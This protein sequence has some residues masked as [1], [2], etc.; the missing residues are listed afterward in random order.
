MTELRR[1]AHE[2][3]RDERRS[4]A[5]A[6]GN[7]F[8]T[9]E[10][11]ETWWRHY[12]G[13]RELLLHALLDEDG[14]AGLLPLYAWR[15]GVVRTLGHGAGDELGP[16]ARPGAEACVVEAA[17]GLARPLLIADHV[18][19]NWIGGRQLRVERS[20]VIDATVFEGWDA[21]LRS[22]SS[23]LRRQVRSRTRKLA[24]A[25]FREADSATLEADLDTLFRLHRL[26][27]PA[28]S[29]FSDREAF[30][31]DFAR[32]G[33]ERGW[34]S[35][36]VLEVGGVAAAAWYGFRFADV[37]AY[38]QSGRD[39]AFDD[40][41]VGLVLL[42]RTI[43]RAFADGRTQYRF[44]RGDEPY[45]SRFSTDDSYV[46]TVALGPAA[47]ATELAAKAYLVSRDTAKRLE[48][49]PRRARRADAHRPIA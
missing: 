20:P 44:L 47:F 38:Y 36:V 19:A 11:H 6:V 37:D 16:V 40:R 12:G 8:A 17:R 41:S 14:L 27:W 21:F 13:G 34:S 29:E 23:N 3:L 45:K 15:R 5:E 33:L 31:R 9:P 35:L 2:E 46:A 48:R 28:G 1:I 49:S 26:R 24:E 30:H 32:V 42:A 4:L 25:T 39:P 43:E 7:V 18:A 10:F 22:R